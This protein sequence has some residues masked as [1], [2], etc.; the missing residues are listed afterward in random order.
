MAQLHRSLLKLLTKARDAAL[1]V[2]M[3]VL[4]TTTS[5]FV[6]AFYE[7]IFFINQINFLGSAEKD[8]KNL[9]K[10]F[11]FSLFSVPAG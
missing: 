9:R 2:S 7:T 3:V 4:C 5:S 1:A 8:F 11:G 10:P 6:Q